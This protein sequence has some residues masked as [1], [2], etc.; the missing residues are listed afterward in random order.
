M[1]I[2]KATILELESLTE[3]FD[4]YRV[5][6]EHTSILIVQGSF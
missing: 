5:F 1:S 2:Q 6:Y 3:L 4:L